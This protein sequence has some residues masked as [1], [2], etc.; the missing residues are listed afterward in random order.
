MRPAQYLLSADA[1]KFFNPQV[2]AEQTRGHNAVHGEHAPPH[3]L[4][5]SVSDEMNM[6]EK[7]LAAQNNATALV[8]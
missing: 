5:I 4:G 2:V 7:I 6:N 1:G 3:R 8:C